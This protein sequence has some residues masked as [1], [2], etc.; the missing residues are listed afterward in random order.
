MYMPEN[1]L[2]YKFSDISF[3]KCSIVWGSSKRANEDKEAK[4]R[5]R[6]PDKLAYT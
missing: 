4:M 6:K 2:F 3:L 5:M 1:K